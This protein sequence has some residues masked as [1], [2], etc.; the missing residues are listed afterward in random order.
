MVSSMDSK[1]H[2]YRN[3]F[4]EP[5]KHD[6]PIMKRKLHISNNERA[7]NTVIKFNN[8]KQLL[9]HERSTD[10]TGSQGKAELKR[11]MSTPKHIVINLG[12]RIANGGTP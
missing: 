6:L 3:P 9:R 2:S 12:S 7:Q 10:T 1:I 8:K 4:K 11:N 5:Q